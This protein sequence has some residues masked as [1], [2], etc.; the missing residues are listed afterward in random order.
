[1]LD[2]CLI[3]HRTAISTCFSMNYISYSFCFSIRLFT[4]T[5]RVRKSKML[6]VGFCIS[7]CRHLPALMKSRN[8]FL[9]F[10]PETEA[11]FENQALY[12]KAIIKSQLGGVMGKVRLVGIPRYATAEDVRTKMKDYIR[13]AHYVEVWKKRGETDNCGI[14]EVQFKTNELRFSAIKKSNDWK[15]SWDGRRVY[16]N[17][18][19]TEFEEEID[20]PLRE[21]LKNL[22]DSWHG[23]EKTGL[24][25]AYKER[26]LMYNDTLLC[27]QNIKTFEMEWKIARKDCVSEA[28]IAKAPAL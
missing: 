26:A 18:V 27:V 8:L 22:K 16:F 25:M 10:R 2:L 3:Y 5:I 9:F 20:K 14:A 1:M 23:G 17:I 19:K 11:I 12:R 15:P 24:R 13:E 28:A 6:N 7:I 21:A 4:I